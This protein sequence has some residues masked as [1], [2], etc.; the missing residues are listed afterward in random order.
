[1]AKFIGITGI[2]V[3]GDA[4]THARIRQEEISAYGDL[5]PGYAGNSWIT[6]TGTDTRWFVME[7]TRQLQ[8]LLDDVTAP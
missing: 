4:I 8:A 1:M 5:P 6:F 3:I 7:T 2:S